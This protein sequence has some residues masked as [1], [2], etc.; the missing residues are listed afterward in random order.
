MELH[1]DTGIIETLDQIQEYLIYIAVITFVSS[2]ALE[3][4]SKKNNID[5]ESNNPKQEESLPTKSFV[6]LGYDFI[7]AEFSIYINLAIQWNLNRV[8]GNTQRPNSEA[9]FR[10]SSYRLSES[11]SNLTEGKEDSQ[12]LILELIPRIFEQLSGSLK[13]IIARSDGGSPSLSAVR[14]G[15]YIQDSD[16][17][18]IIIREV[19]KA[20]LTDVAIMTKDDPDSRLDLTGIILK[21][22]LTT[23]SSGEHF[24]DESTFCQLQL[25]LARFI[26]LETL[27]MQATEDGD[28]D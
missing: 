1:P 12:R 17:R 18:R 2:I 20:A 3:V 7:V 6:Q 10:I 8:L 15:L 22:V 27:R 13:R 26:N 9:T 14:K 11:E 5:N 24:V 21:A 4:F 25:E 19:W 23:K 16:I 28:F